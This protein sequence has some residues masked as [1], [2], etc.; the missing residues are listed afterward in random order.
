MALCCWLEAL[1]LAD[2]D[3]VLQACI[4]KSPLHKPVCSRFARALTFSECV[5]QDSALAL[6]VRLGL[7]QAGAD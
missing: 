1:Q 3:S 7:A 2:D 4:L 5:L 6:G